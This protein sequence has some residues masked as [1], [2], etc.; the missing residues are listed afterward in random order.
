MVLHA[1]NNLTHSLFFLKCTCKDQTGGRESQGLQPPTPPPHSIL[2][3]KNTRVR[4]KMQM[5]AS[6]ATS[7]ITKQQ[8]Y[9]FNIER[10]Y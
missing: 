3:N 2:S 4:L 6:A 1:S 5:F 9:G 8:L 7:L 10:S